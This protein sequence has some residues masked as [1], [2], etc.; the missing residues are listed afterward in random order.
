MNERERRPPRE[1]IPPKDEVDRE[2]AFHIEM[3]TRDL[4][5]RGMDPD[6]AR[7]NAI[8]RFGGLDRMERE[9]RDLARNRDARARRMEALW[10]FRQD[11]V[12]AARALR[13]QPAFTALAT[14]ILGVGVGVTVSIL[15]LAKDT[16]FT[17]PPLVRNAVQLVRIN[18]V[19]AQGGTVSNAYPDFA[20]FDSAR[21]AFTTL[22]S[23][24]PDAAVAMLRTTGDAEPVAVHFATADFFPTLGVRLEQGRT[25]AADEDAEGAARVAVVSHNVAELQFGDAGRAVGG[26]IL[27]NGNPFTIVGV[28]PQRFRGASLEDANADVW[29][30]L[31]ARPFITG[32]TR[33]DFVRTPGSF[34][35]FL[36]VIGRMKPSISFAAAEQDVASMAAR[37]TQATGDTT[38]RF[39]LSAPFSL[40]PR[41]REALVRM[42]RL[43]GVAALMVLLIAC[44]NLSNLFLARGAARSREL[45]VRAALGAGRFRL[46]RHVLTESVLLAVTGALFGAVAAIWTTRLVGALLPSSLGAAGRLDVKLLLAALAVAGAA[47][48]L[49]SLAAGSQALRFEA[50]SALRAGTADRAGSTRIR[51]ALVV[52]QVA[53]SFALLAGAGLF[54][55]TLYGVRSMPL[56]YELRNQL[57]AFV[58]LRA[59]GYADSAGALFFDRLLERAGTIPG[60][61]SAALALTLP[62]ASGRRIGSLHVEGLA[63]PAGQPSFDVDVNPVTPGFFATLGTPLV[64]GR[65]F[66]PSDDARAPGVVIVNEAMA[67]RFWPNEDALGKHVRRGEKEPWLTVVGVVRDARYV[68]ATQ[69]A[70]PTL[71]RPFAQNSG[72]RMRLLLHTTGDPAAALPPLRRVVNELDPRVIVRNPATL[73]TTY[74]RATERFVRNARLVTVLGVLAL[75]L[76]VAGLYAVMSYL[77]MH[78]QR[79]FGVRMALGARPGTVLRALTREGLFLTTGGVALGMIIAVASGRLVSGFL[80]GVKPVDGVAFVAALVV[81]TSAALAASIVPARRASKIDPMSAL[82]A[83]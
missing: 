72:S 65:D 6:A 12:V 18:R 14:L 83:D 32:R 62:L 43:F 59:A 7:R 45:V 71:F 28:L 57:T 54:V 2:I 27:L 36:I 25:F 48:M 73:E 1:V 61:R 47:A 26:S 56:G 67:R 38:A 46:V 41:T 78:R 39:V 19:G 20:F 79:E 16:L 63:P 31:W 35:G 5:A 68:S 49:A 50:A 77:A 40:D 66:A 29:L 33:Q 69:E 37:L 70:V 9:L 21:T 64:A 13:K 81:L 15:S 55:R 42:L 76:S 4:V 3:R 34:H 24:A 74:E 52:A 53:F 80:F 11:I 44:S 30:P 82:R 8:A 60:V 23:Y 10:S 51:S 75:V 22:T 58:D 17:P